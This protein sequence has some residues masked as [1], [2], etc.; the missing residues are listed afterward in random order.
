MEL[1]RD[2]SISEGLDGRHIDMIASNEAD[3]KEESSQLEVPLVISD[4]SYYCYYRK[5]NQNLMITLVKNQ[6]LDYQLKFS[7]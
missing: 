2:I 4:G 3:G 7:L 6:N 1:F 5:A